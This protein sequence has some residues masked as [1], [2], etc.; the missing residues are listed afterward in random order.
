VAH[1]LAE[2]KLIP[3]HATSHNCLVRRGRRRLLREIWYTLG[4]CIS[5]TGHVSA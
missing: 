1:H 4:T 2:M 5:E 3:I